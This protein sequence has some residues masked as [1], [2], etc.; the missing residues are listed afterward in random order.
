MIRFTTVFSNFSAMT[1]VLQAKARSG[2]I[3]RAGLK[4]LQKK[5]GPP[6]FDESPNRPFWS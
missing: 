1:F 4:V 3:F 6:F 5:A 2:L